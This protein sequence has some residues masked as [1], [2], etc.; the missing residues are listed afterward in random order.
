MAMETAKVAL[1]TAKIEQRLLHDYTLPVKKAG[2]ETALAKATTEYEKAAK[3]T[4]AQYRSKKSAVD[5]AKKNVERIQTDLSLATKDLDALEVKSPASG[6]VTYGSPDEYWRRGEIQVG[7][8]LWPGQV[9]MSVPVMSSMIAAVNVSESD[10]RNVR[11]GQVARVRVEAMSGRLFDGEV[12]KVAEVAN[13]GG[14][15][16]KDV[17]DFKVE[18]SMKDLVSAFKRVWDEAESRGKTSEIIAESFSV[19]DKISEIL[20]RVSA[21][22]EGISFDSLFTRF[23]KVEIIV[24]FLAILE[25]IRQKSIK[26]LQN[27]TFGN[28]YI[29]GMEAA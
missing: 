28:I 7:A 21:A 8:K 15:L 27:E 5:V 25:L 13:A 10:I 11:T 16:V 17:K 20:A 9:L 24:T 12:I 22:P 3:Q 2:Y 19:K 29:Y 1:D 14:W 26:I 23:A 4:A 6:I 18:V